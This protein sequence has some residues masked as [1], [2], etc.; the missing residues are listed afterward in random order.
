MKKILLLVLLLCLIISAFIIFGGTH[1]GDLLSSGR[2]AEDENIINIGVFESAST[3]NLSGVMQEEMGF[4]F[5]NSAQNKVTVDGTEYTIALKTVDS[6]AKDFDELTAAGALIDGEK[7]SAVLASK[8]YSISSE[9][10]QLFEQAGIPVVGA[11][12]TETVTEGKSQLCF[13]MNN[14]NSLQAGALA[15]FAYSRGLKSAALV[16]KVGDN[17]SKELAGLFQEEFTRLGGE[18]IEFHYNS[19]QRNF[20]SL[21]KDI[22]K[23][24]IDMV[25][26]PASCEIASI[27]INHSRDAGLTVPIFGAGQFDSS[28]LLKTLGDNGSE[29]YF[30]SIFNQDST[31]NPKLADF[32]LKY[33]EWINNDDERA[34]KNGSFSYVS[35]YSALGYDAY[36]MLFA[37][38]KQA[39]SAQPEQIAQALQNMEY[40]GICG[41]VSFLPQQQPIK[42]TVYIKTVNTR[43]NSFELIQESSASK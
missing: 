34:D 38:I 40:E 16:T 9:A 33:R 1:G 27:F 4:A 23:E 41:L 5:A 17:Y 19:A 36:N 21:A 43:S 25:Y 35:S 6:T 2:N 24:K 22:K 42:R 11:Y 8:D 18:I 32:V 13:G 31:V 14:G 10:A 15:N 3:D 37:A 29:I 20:E 28:I 7:I 26:L 12:A 30:S 39:N